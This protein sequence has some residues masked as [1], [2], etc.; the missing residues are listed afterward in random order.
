M[1]LMPEN[2]R[3]IAEQLPSELGIGPEQLVAEAYIDLLRAKAV[4]A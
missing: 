4:G 2:V 1:E 3:R